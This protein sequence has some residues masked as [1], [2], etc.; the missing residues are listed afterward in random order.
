MRGSTMAGVPY[1]IHEHIAS[2]GYAWRYRCYPSTPARAHVVFVHG[3]QSH[4]GWYEQSCTLLSRA[5]FMVSFL[6][7]RGSGMNEARRGDAPRFRRLVDDVVEYLQTLRKSGGLPLFLAGISWGGKLVAAVEARHPGLI[8]GLILLCPGF[9]PQVRPGRRE[10]LRIVW[11]R[12]V[13]P[14]KRFPIPL[15][16]PALFTASVEWQRFIREDALSLREATA[17][18]LIESV[19]LDWYLRWAP[20]RVR[21]PV[22]LLLAERDRIID[23]ERT[24]RYVDRFATADREMIV[25]AGAQHTLEFEPARAEMVRNLESWL[26][27]HVVS[28]P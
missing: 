26:G 12:L 24:R 20:G 5:G 9:F 21:I 6:D 16:D 7:R 14:E 2:D 25:Y 4:A 15:N 17:R 28:Q 10:R 3:I 11:A 19:R 8:D 22:L 1:T 23:N 18:L 27:K 13:A